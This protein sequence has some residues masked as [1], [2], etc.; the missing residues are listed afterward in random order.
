MYGL[1][2]IDKEGV[3]LWDPKDIGELEYDD[4]FDLTK[5]SNQN[6][7]KQICVDLRLKSSIVLDSKVECWIEDFE[8]WLSG[9]GGSGSFPSTSI[10]SDLSLYIQTA[11]GLEYFYKNYIGLIDNKLKFTMIRATSQ[12]VPNSPNKYLKPIYENW[13]SEMESI[14]KNSD[15]GLNE[16]IVTGGL[17]FTWMRTEEEFV[18]TAQN[19]IIISMI[20]AFV[21]L[22]L[23][24]LNLLISIFSIIC[25]A[26]VILSVVAIM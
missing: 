19:G 11:K 1:K 22:N 9:G 15:L 21:I 12:G 7:L 8:S 25:I 17:W 5:A 23:S 2:G 13:V 16:G 14:N 18:R 26:L 6:R 20:F 4:S 10:I 24:T 3:D